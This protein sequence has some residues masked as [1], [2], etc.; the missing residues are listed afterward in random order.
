LSYTWSFLSITAFSILIYNVILKVQ[1]I[2]LKELESHSQIYEKM[3]LIN[4]LKDLDQA[5]ITNRA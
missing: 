5:E 4:S 2:S 1:N 3:A